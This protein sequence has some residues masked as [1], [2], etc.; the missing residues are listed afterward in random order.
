MVQGMSTA[1]LL[2]MIFWDEVMVR[3]ALVAYSN[4][5]GWREPRT[6]QN[7]VYC[8]HTRTPS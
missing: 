2:Y 7:V 8:L 4:C 1:E 6:I 5:V 3:C